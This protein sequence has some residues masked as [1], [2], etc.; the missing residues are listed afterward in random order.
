VIWFGVV[1]IGV[2]LINRWL[3][4]RVEY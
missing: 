2:G 4:S 3:K 1:L